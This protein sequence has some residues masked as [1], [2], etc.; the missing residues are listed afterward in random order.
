[1][2]AAASGGEQRGVP[3][4][5]A[6]G[7]ERLGVFFGRIEHHVDD[8]LDAAVS[9]GEPADIQAKPPRERGAHLML[10]EDLALDFAGLHNL[11]GE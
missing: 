9:R 1:V 7:G 8:A 10:V 6:L 4:E 5:Q 3:A 11:L 2:H